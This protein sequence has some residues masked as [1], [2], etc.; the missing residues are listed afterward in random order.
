MSWEGWVAQGA[1]QR[2]A[3]ES[4]E[5]LPPPT[6]GCACRVLQARL[7][8]APPWLLSAPRP[9]LAG[10]LLCC[11]RRLCPRWRRLSRRSPVRGTWTLSPPPPA[12]PG[13][14]PPPGPGDQEALRRVRVPEA[15]R[16]PALWSVLSAV[17][18]AASCPA[19]LGPLSPPC[20]GQTLCLHAELG[21]SPAPW[22][23]CRGC[24]C[25]LWSV[26]C[27]LP[28]PGALAAFC[29]L[30][31]GTSVPAAPGKR[32][33][34]GPSPHGPGWLLWRPCRLQ[35]RLPWAPERQGHTLWTRV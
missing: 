26:G 32:P 30:L 10:F 1:F 22:L 20:T 27:P 19:A 23:S 17:R 3:P 5:R 8:A 35:A 28:S 12:L 31:G 7:A 14:L 29:L 21:S 16:P 34:V 9:S 18:L 25:L 4:P 15:H 13:V 11:T 24:R 33:A 6:L 2:G